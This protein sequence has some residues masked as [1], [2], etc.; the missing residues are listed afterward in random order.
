MIAKRRRPLP[1]LLMAHVD[2][3]DHEGTRPSVRADL[4][5]A[6]KCG[7][8][9]LGANV[10]GSGDDELVVPYTCKSRACPSCGHRA[11]VA[12]QREQWV[13]LPEVPYAHVCLTMPD[14]LWPMFRHNRHVLHDLPAVGAT[15]V[16]QLALQRY[17]VRLIIMVIQHTFGGHLNFNCHLHMLISQGGLREDGMGLRDNCGFDRKTLMELWRSSVIEL[18]RQ[19]AD[20][21]VLHVGIERADLDR[22]LSA[23]ADRK[24]IININRFSNKTHFLAYAGRYARR[25]PVAQHRFTKI[26]RQEIRYMTKNTRTKT[27]VETVFTPTDFLPRWPIMFPIGI[28]TVFDTSAYWHRG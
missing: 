26:S 25:P 22:I 4:H 8:E 21:G 11:T 5:K 3:W 9:A 27:R 1:A 16:Q 19:T 17:G 18:L 23:Q 14:V 24:W 6:I 20:A 15:V 28:I 12:W 7:T 13:D 2:K 10:F